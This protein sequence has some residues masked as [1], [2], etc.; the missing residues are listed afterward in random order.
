MLYAASFIIVKGTKL[1]DEETLRHADM[2]HRR[3]PRGSSFTCLAS[4]GELPRSVGG[5][6]F[7]PW[8]SPLYSGPATPQSMSAPAKVHK[9]SPGRFVAFDGRLKHRTEPFEYQ[10]V[11]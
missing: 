2:G 8:E 1:E 11:P 5:L 7:W 4:L 10:R 6:Q 3:I 9:Y